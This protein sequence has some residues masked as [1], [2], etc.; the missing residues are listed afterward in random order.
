[1]NIL[2]KI[3]LFVSLSIIDI[4]LLTYILLQMNN[5]NPDPYYNYSFDCSD[6]HYGCCHYINHCSINNNNLY[7]NLKKINQNGSNCP[8]YSEII[9]SYTIDKDHHQCSHNPITPQGYLLY[10]EWFNCCP[11]N[12]LCD[13]NT[14]P[15]NYTEY[16]GS[17]R[18]LDYG[19]TTLKLQKDNTIDNLSGC[20]MMDDFMINYNHL[21]FENKINIYIYVLSI[22]STIIVFILCNIL[23]H[24][25]SKD[26]YRGLEEE[27]VVQP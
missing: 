3:I 10:S 27:E 5:N 14:L 7:L 21:L 18:A 22:C 17:E 25:S 19:W 23:N 16:S 9:N 13:S 1:M 20:P 26:N 12:I 11:V 8:N 4:Y 2:K 24:I 15:E 6:S